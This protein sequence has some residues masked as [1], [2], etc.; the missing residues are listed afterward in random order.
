MLILFKNFSVFRKRKSVEFQNDQTYFYNI[1]TLKKSFFQEPCKKER[2][3]LKFLQPTP[4]SFI[5]SPFVDF[6]RRFTFFQVFFLN[7]QFI[8]VVYA[9]FYKKYFFLK[10]SDKHFIIQLNSSKAYKGNILNL[11]YQYSGCNEILYFYFFNF[12]IFHRPCR[13][14]GR[15]Y[16]YIG[17]NKNKKIRRFTGSVPS[18][19]DQA[20]C[21]ISRFCN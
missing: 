20:G 19:R 11:H 4:L 13:K 1:W 2:V 21:C 15:P 17:Q 16:P 10:K 14:T 18:L 8:S 9:R 7:N 5:C 3:C 12:S 6:L